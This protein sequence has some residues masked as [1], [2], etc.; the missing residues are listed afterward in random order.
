M[1]TFPPAP[2]DSRLQV[3][4]E[5]PRT[6]H[7]RLGLW[8]PS[9]GALQDSEEKNDDPADGIKDDCDQKRQKKQEGIKRSGISLEPVSGRAGY[10]RPDGGDFRRAGKADP[11]YSTRQDVGRVVDSHVD[12]R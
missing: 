10:E 8:R 6:T 11:N 5:I 2:R 3:S 9:K 7:C 1:W 12:S 4:T